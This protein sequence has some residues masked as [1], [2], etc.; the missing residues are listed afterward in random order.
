VIIADVETF[1]VANPPPAFGGRYFVFVKLT[2]DD[3][4]VGI[5]EAYSAAFRPHVVSAGIEDLADQ[6]L[7]GEDPFHIERFWRRAYSR[8]FSQ[9]PDPTLL[10]AVSAL[11]M[12]CWD[13]VGKAVDKPVYELLGG[14]VHE[15]LRGYTYLYPRDSDSTDVYLDPVLAAE[16]AADEVERGFTALKFDPAGP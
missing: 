15:A 4:I 3:G 11:E 2:T 10:G 7:L 14:R 12:A 1:V 5:G 16:R 9:R 13:I 8:G 6:Y